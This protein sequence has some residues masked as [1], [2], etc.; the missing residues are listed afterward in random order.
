MSELKLSRLYYASTATEVYLH[1]DI[2]EILKSCKTVNPSLD[3]TGMLFFGE[4]YFLQCLEGSRENINFLYRKIARDPR[5]KDVELLE[6]KDIN[7]RYFE[8]WSMKYVSSANVIFKILKQTGLRK[9]NPYLLDS[10]S[11]NAMTEVF[12]D[13]VPTDKVETGVPNV[14]KR[15]FSFF[16]PFK[17]L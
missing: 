4:G 6:F 10:Y 7:E 5:H 14:K 15:G 1:H 9:F 16:N 13:Y 17:H 8:E 11:L 2:G 3:V 12:R